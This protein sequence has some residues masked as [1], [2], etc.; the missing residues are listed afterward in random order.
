MLLISVE[1]RILFGFDNGFVNGIPACCVETPV[2]GGVL[3]AVD[4]NFSSLQFFVSVDAHDII[5]F[6]V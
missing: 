5:L 2:V 1:N 3:V 6:I 4:S